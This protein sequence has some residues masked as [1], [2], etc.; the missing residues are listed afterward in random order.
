MRKVGLLACLLTLT[1][2]SAYA[3]EGFL[4]GK[5]LKIEMKDVVAERGGSN[6]NLTL[7]GI[8]S[9]SYVSLL[10]LE[11]AIKKAAEDKD[12]AMIYINTDKFSAGLAPM[13]EVRSY[14]KGFSKAGKPVIAYGTS[15]GNGS[16]YIASVA[17][18]VF[19][20]PTGGAAING[21]SSTQYFLKDALDTLGI[22]VQL[23][24]HGK[25]KSAGEMYIR[26]D[27]SPEN[28]EQYEVM[29]DSIWG[30]ILD[31]IAESRGISVDDLRNWIE[32]LE[33]GKGQTLVDKGLVDGLK[34][35]DEMEQ[36]L[37]HLF[38]TTEPSEVKTV[39]IKNYMKKLKDGPSSK[40]IAVVYA[41][42][43]IGEGRSVGEKVANEIAKVRRDSTVKA[44]VFRVNSPGGEVTASDIIR[45]EIELLKKYKPVIASYGSYAASG[46][47]LISAGCDKI[48]VD[49]TTLTGSIGVFGMF[50]NV[51]G[52]I[53]QNLKVNPVQIG[54][55]KH[56]TMMTG[57]YPLS[58]EEQAWCQD[59]IE[60][61]YD[62]F[63]TV[64]S[65][66][67]NISKE[68]VDSIAQGRVWTG[69]DAIGIKLADET[70][71]ILEAVEYA[72]K[73][74]NLKKYSIVSY[75]RKKS[76]KEQLLD[77]D[78]KDETKPLV[79]SIIKPGF[80]VVARMPY[81]TFESET[82][83]LK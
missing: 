70:G 31:E 46:G 29:L 72:A 73:I 52:A 1:L 71:T 81:F 19:L 51:G 15:F 77:K 57:M 8:K 44:V 54:T 82:L 39:D 21:L 48:F 7:S 63:V 75:P 20:Y 78:D 28:R 23:I 64:V 24:R 25:Y 60:K 43:E 18:R 40:K 13:E 59:K 35:R 80:S 45:R 12:I 3:G 22:G 33:I 79:K 69:K 61:V 58:E 65:E 9:S 2:F 76:F 4:K 26:N 62:D 67:R 37:C 47:Y 6:Y 34:Y 10:S 11:R 50:Y 17:D 49:K 41:N 32:N 36:Y 83:L 38:G 30:S 42:G 14:L 16:Y 55:G 27:I 5:I 53:K 74:S 56:S 66:G 68:Y